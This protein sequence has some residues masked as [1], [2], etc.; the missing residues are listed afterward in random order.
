M[1]GYSHDCFVLIT[2]Y[3]AFLIQLPPTILTII[4]VQWRLDV[5]TKHKAKQTRWQKLKRIDFIGTLLS[6]E[7]E[8]TLLTAFL[9]RS[10]LSV[11]IHLLRLLR[12]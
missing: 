11:R 2:S 6:L 8:I 3:R 10:I 9:R 4:L 7:T 1:A 5:P 12:T